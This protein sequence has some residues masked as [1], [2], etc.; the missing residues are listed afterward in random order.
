MPT[1]KGIVYLCLVLKSK[2]TIGIKRSRATK[3]PAVDR[4]QAFCLSLL[5]NTFQSGNVAKPPDSEYYSV[6]RTYSERAQRDMQV[7]IAPNN[8]DWTIRRA[9][10]QRVLRDIITIRIGV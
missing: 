1:V 10:S 9:L 2:T 8:T 3:L 6:F 4:N 7:R 5:D